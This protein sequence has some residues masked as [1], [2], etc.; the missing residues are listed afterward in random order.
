MA[1]SETVWPVP[2]ARQARDDGACIPSPLSEPRVPQKR[3]TPQALEKVPYLAARWK[4]E[5]QSERGAGGRA[6]KH[7]ERAIHEAAVAAAAC[8]DGILERCPAPVSE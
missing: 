7:L 8:D 3:I 2:N 4:R 5:G 6:R 1:G